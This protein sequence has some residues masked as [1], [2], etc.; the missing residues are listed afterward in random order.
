MQ[1]GANKVCRNEG[2]P[3][4]VGTFIMGEMRQC[5]RCGDFS[6]TFKAY[7]YKSRSLQRVTG[8]YF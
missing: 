2:P 6:G 7:E 1:Q 5:D 8:V 3:H 4:G